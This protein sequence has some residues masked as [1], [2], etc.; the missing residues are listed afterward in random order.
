[1]VL[2]QPTLITDSHITL[3][4]VWTREFMSTTSRTDDGW[5]ETLGVVNTS[6]DDN[7]YFKTSSANK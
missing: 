1:M 3:L 6:A 7:I 5:M 4:T 2:V